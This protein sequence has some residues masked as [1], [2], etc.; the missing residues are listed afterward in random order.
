MDGV[1]AYLLTQGILGVVALVERIVIIRLYN[2][3]ERQEKEKG[4]LQEAR[5][6]DAVETRTDVTSILPGI[7][8]SLQNISDKIEIS[9]SNAGNRS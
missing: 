6:L 5:R 7:S 1:T 3:N 4:D 2:K 9:R 8:Q